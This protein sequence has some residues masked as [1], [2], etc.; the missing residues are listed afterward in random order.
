[1]KN[2][3]ILLLVVYSFC[4]CKNNAGTGGSATIKGKVY[5]RKYD[6]NYT[7]VVGEGNA[8]AKKVYIIYGNDLGV[9]QYVDTNFDGTYEFKYLQKGHYKIFMYTIDTSGVYKN[10]MNRTAPPQYI[11]K[12]V[13]ITSGSQ[14]T[15]VNFDIIPVPKPPKI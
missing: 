5:E 11:L 8:D 14:I 3:I 12:E 13:D 7:T 10:A 6:Y 1:M 2:G 4:S 9:G 15:N